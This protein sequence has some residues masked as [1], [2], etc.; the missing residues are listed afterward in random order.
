MRTST[1]SRR[2]AVAGAWMLSAMVGGAVTGC[3]GGAR[4]VAGVAPVATSGTRLRDWPAE[5]SVQTGY[6]PVQGRRRLTGS[7]ASISGDETRTQHMM[8]VEELLQ[9]LPGVS[10]TPHGDGSF[11]VVIR[12][13]SA[14]SAYGR[15]DPLF[16]ID[17]MPAADGTT[18]LNSLSPQD[19]E[20]IDVLKDAEAS[21]YGSRSGNGVI[22]IRT[23]HAKINQE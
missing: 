20:R 5:D 21:I 6:S 4:P 17:G 18:V 3:A 8:R 9:R 14:M 15:T 2:S 23:R 19:I 22:L 12:G 10:V 1:G 11:S 13:A 16:V 7:V